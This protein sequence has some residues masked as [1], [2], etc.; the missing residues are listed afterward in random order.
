VASASIPRNINT[1]KLS[2]RMRLSSN[3]FDWRT[4]MTLK[5]FSVPSAKLL[6]Y[7]D[8][9]WGEHYQALTGPPV[10]RTDYER[11]A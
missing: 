10:L 8:E 1:D 5:L 9:A 4:S 7:D 6:R 2:A 3:T 11:D